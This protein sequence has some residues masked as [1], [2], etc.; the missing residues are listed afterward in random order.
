MLECTYT[1]IYCLNDRDRTVVSGRKFWEKPGTVSE[2]D[3]PSVPITLQVK[4]Q[5]G[6]VIHQ[7]I[8]AVTAA[9]G[10][11]Y[12]FEDVPVMDQEGHAYSYE[13]TEP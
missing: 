3:L 4:D 7:E 6:E 12:R 10:W 8:Q 1:L 13:V 2:D 9:N 5:N 11:A